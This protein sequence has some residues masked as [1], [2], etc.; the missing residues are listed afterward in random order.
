[1]AEMGRRR[2]VLLSLAILIALAGAAMAASQPTLAADMCLTGEEAVLLDRINTWRALNGEPPLVASPALTAAARHHA[3]SMATH[4]YFPADY[5][6]RFEGPQRDETITWQENITNAGYPD[7]SATIRSAI[8]GAGSSSAPAIIRTLSEQASFAAV[9]ADARFRAIGIGIATNPESDAGVYWTLT[10]GSVRD[11]AIDAC[12]G[13]PLPV[14]IAASGRSA[15]SALSG[16][17]YDGDLKTVWMTETSTPPRSA[18]IW[19]DL[20]STQRIRAIEWMFARGGA[21]DHF[22]IEVST[23]NVTWTAVATKSNGAVGAWRS[24]R[25]SGDA[26]FIRF[27]FLNP[28]GDPVLGYLA[29]VRVL[30]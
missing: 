25:F 7:N 21:A 29:E 23:D 16:V 6:V 17:A 14:A 26:R 8:I 11:G 15:N 27:A 10:F 22:Q 28:N 18:H 2:A 20:G 9:L 13:V 5:S 1:M 12:P 3:Q 19:F 4:N 24:A 30:A